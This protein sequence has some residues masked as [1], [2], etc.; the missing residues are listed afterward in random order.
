M[1]Q[2]VAM[3][4]QTLCAPITLQTLRA[5]LSENLAV[6]DASMHEQ[7]IPYLLYEEEDACMRRRKGRFMMPPC[8]NRVSPT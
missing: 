3:T 6:L 8:T 4:P 1:S 7:S 5:V 2:G